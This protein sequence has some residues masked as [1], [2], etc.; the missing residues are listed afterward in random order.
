[1]NTMSV[2]EHLFLIFNIIDSLLFPIAEKTSKRASPLED[3]KTLNIFLLGRSV[4]EYK[5]K[6]KKNLPEASAVLIFFSPLGHG[7]G[8][9]GRTVLSLVWKIKAQVD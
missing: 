7:A 6:T 3:R 9:R 1:M 2:T 8:K 4:S 5:T